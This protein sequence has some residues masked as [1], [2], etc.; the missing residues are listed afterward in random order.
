M[1][2]GMIFFGILV[3]ILLIYQWRKK[4]EK[5]DAIWTGSD[6]SD[7]LERWTY[8]PEEWKKFA[9]DD[10]RWVKHK[11]LAGD[12]IISDSSILISNGLD[13]F[14]R[15]LHREWTLTEIEFRET[16]SIFRIKL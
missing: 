15:D 6:D 2:C 11:D 1:T 13:K 9:E 3:F 12:L 14:Y 5:I 8:S 16:T 4:R 7:L 10:F